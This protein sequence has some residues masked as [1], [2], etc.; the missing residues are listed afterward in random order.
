MVMSHATLL[1]GLMAGLLAGGAVMSTLLRELWPRQVIASARLGELENR[2]YTLHADLHE[3]QTRV[4]EA[5][6]RRNRLDSER[7]RLE[8]EIRRM[9]RA[10]E[11]LASRPPLFVH[12]LGDPQHGHACFTVE[13]RRRIDSRSSAQETSVNPI[14]HHP[15]VAEVWARTKEE[16]HQL[17]DVAFPT[18]LGYVKSFSANNATETEKLIERIQ[19]AHKTT[20]PKEDEG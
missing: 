2:L 5:I 20:S 15:N 13:V 3:R 19:L 14:W 9:E 16:A 10:L 8:S 11:E 4:Q 7:L 1:L 17:V 12:E 6:Q 18:K